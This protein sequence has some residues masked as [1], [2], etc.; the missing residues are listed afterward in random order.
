MATVHFELASKPLKNGEFRIRIRLTE[1]RKLSRRNTVFSVPA[2]WWNPQIEEVRRG[3]PHAATINASLVQLRAKLLAELASQ[4]LAGVPAARLA[5]HLRPERTDVMA[6]MSKLVAQA[7]AYRT[8]RN[9]N[10]SLNHLRNFVQADVL[11]ADQVTYDFARA[12]YTYLRNIGQLVSTAR[13]HVD[14]LR[15]GYMLLVRGGHVRPQRDFWPELDIP[16]SR[17]RVSDRP[18]LT[19]GEITQIAEFPLTAAQVKYGWH[20][21]AWVFMY[22]A[23][24]MRVGAALQLRWR[25]IQSDRIIYQAEKSVKTLS[26]LITPP[27]QEILDRYRQP[28]LGPDDYVFPQLRFSASQK[29]IEKR[30]ESETTKMSKALRVIAARLGI[31]KKISTHAARHSFAENARILSNNDIYAVSRALGHN[32]VKVTQQYFDADNL[33][34]ADELSRLVV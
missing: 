20:R 25:N 32:D 17:R 15:R 28:E 22:Y 1:N 2:K 9:R 14:L 13:R 29:V 18:R 5:D 31:E 30:V 33:N 3:H 21:D 26:V 7:E 4:Q 11:P 23:R 19:P 16:V 27:M 10:T 8:R 34:D 6:A 12:Y 24:G